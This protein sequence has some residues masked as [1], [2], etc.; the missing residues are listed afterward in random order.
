MNGRWECQIN[1][2][3][4]MKRI[5]TK[6]VHTPKQFVKRL[7]QNV[8]TTQIQKVFCVNK[9]NSCHAIKEY[10]MVKVRNHSFLT[11]A[12]GGGEGWA[13]GFDVITPAK[14]HLYSWIAG[15]VDNSV[16]LDASETKKIH[17]PLWYSNTIPRTCTTWFSHHTDH[18]IFTL[19]P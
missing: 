1:I 6:P 12:L 3:V 2:H 10:G 9:R 4:F 19:F 18:V 14:C 13:S 17:S 15:W 11:E 5:L 16:R 8:A 7:P